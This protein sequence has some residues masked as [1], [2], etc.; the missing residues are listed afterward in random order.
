MSVIVSEAVQLLEM[1]PENDQLISCEFLRKLARQ[2]Q[3]ESLNEE[4]LE[5]MRNVQNGVNLSKTFHSI[6]E[7]ME[8][9]DADDPI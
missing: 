7:L 2:Y 9:L 8:D 3:D 5:A 6:S 4:T 1:L